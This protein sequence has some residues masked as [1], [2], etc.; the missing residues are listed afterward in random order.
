VLAPGE[1][2]TLDLHWKLDSAAQLPTARKVF[3]HV[4]DA[5]EDQNRI[6]EHDGRPANWTLPTTCWLPGQVVHD[7]HP[8]T[9]DASAKPGEYTVLVG[10]YDE[11]TGERTF[12]HT[13]QVAVAN[14]VA[15]PEKLQVE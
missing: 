14:A 12:V 11:F 10:L 2:A 5:P 8:F 3:V 13:A 15:L 6:A 4:S 1:S 7:P 9:V